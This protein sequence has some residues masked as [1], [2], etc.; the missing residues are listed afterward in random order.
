MNRKGGNMNYNKNQKNN[1]K[2]KSY[3]RSGHKSNG[4]FQKGDP[5]YGETAD[6]KKQLK[7]FIKEGNIT[8]LVKFAENTAKK[9]GAKTNQVRRLYSPVIKIQEQLSMNSDKWKRELS[10][11]KPRVVYAAA[12]ENKLKSL[13]EC[14]LT[15][16]ETVEEIDDENK[17]KSAV[18]SFCAFMEAVVAYHK[19]A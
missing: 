9:T 4:R 3:S 18:K 15:C 1:Y 10:M 11:L 8:E 17:K 14:I 5:T 13:K 19:K 6:R 12:R 7:S 16:I 2:G